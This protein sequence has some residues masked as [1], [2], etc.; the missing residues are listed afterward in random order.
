MESDYTVETISGTAIPQGV[1][2]HLTE[3]S[4]I[5]H[6]FKEFFEKE[7]KDRHELDLSQIKPLISKLILETVSQVS[8]CKLYIIGKKCGF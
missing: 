2:T 7:P 1:E 6:K 8:I 3:R 5:F 4:V